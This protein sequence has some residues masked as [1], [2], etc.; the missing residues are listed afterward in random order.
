M[1]PTVRRAS[2]LI[3]NG[4]V[5]L[6]HHGVPRGERACRVG[7]EPAAVRGEDEGGGDGVDARGDGEDG[8]ERRRIVL[9]LRLR[10]RGQAQSGGGGSHQPR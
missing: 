9:L 5:D 10:A 2:G 7:C 6:E 1:N 4:F 8:E 3:P